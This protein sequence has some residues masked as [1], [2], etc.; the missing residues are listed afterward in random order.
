MTLIELIISLAIAALILPLVAGIVFMLQFFPG[1]ATADIQ[2]QQ[3]LQV[4]GQWVTIDCNRANEFSAPTLEE[5]EY[6]TFSWTEYGGTFP[7]VVDVTYF[8]DSESASLVRR[9][10]RDG[11]LDRNFVVAQNIANAEDV[12]FDSDAP[13]I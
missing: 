9:V 2:A 10:T 4:L 8:Y 6:G 13:A 3:N 11:V 1:R 5:N 7:V 12:T